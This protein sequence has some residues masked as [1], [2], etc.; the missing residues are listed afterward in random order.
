MKIY[1]WWVNF[2][3]KMIRKIYGV[4]EKIDKVSKPDQTQDIK[5]N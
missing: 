2:T 5:K 1:F 4:T 3:H